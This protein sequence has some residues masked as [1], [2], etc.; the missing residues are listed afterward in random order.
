MSE[1]LLCITTQIKPVNV[2]WWNKLYFLEIR[3]YYVTSAN[4]VQEC[5]SRVY[6]LRNTN[7]YCPKSNCKTQISKAGF[8]A[9]NSLH[10]NSARDFGSYSTSLRNIG[11]ITQMPACARNN[12]WTDSWVLRGKSSYKTYCILSVYLLLR[13]IVLIPT[14]LWTNGKKKITN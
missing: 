14:D 1:W 4:S 3:D 7:V 5:S 11:G 6:I 13:L 9:A 8:L 10:K 2:L 12:A